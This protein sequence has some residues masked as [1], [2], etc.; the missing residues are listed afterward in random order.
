[1]KGTTSMRSYPTNSPQAA[2]RVLAMALLADGH[3][4][5]LELQALDRMHAA[6]RLGL[7]PSDFKDVLT[8]F[9]QDLLTAHQGQW[10]GSFQR[11]DPRVRNLLMGEVTDPELQH[12]VM[13]LCA[14]TVKADGHLS[15]GEL[16][17]ID[18]LSGTWARRFG[19]TH[20]G[21]STQPT[22][23]ESLS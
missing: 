5:M 11:L 17:M 2:A 10:T 13:Q 16:Q 8:D 23:A 20:A 15:E 1:M 21:A 18:T 6:R 22:V 19:R 14:E 3:Y 7:S 4:S 9:C 12:E